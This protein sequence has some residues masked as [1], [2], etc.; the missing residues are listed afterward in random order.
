M[1]KPASTARLR[2]ARL[3]SHG[4]RTGLPSI[5]AAA[6]R[7]AA[8]QAQDFVAAKWVL[9]A[10]VPGSV[11][12][13]VDSAIESR[14]IVRSW[15][16]RGTLHL[17]PT[18][19]LRPILAITG[20]REVQRDATRRRQLELDD[21]VYAK[22]RDIAERELAGGSLSRD[23][24]FAA[25]EA[26]GIATAAQRGYHLTWWLAVDAVICCGPVEGRGQRFVLLDE[27]APATSAAPDRE[28][29]LGRLFT[30]YA[31]GHGPATVRDFAWWT[32]LTLGDAR[33]AVAAAG[34]T[35][36]AFDDERYV[37]ADAG[38]TADPDAAA[39]R[40]GGRLALAPFDEYFLGY[41]D[42]SPVCD[43]GHAPRVVPSSNGV[44]QPILVAAG[45]VEGVWKVTRARGAASVAVQGF[46]RE[47]DPSRYRSALAAW[48]RFQGE[49]LDAVVAA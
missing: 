11:A 44:F 18:E 22:A 25:W 2:A 43:P 23:E 46:E 6:R 33:T 36:V 10:R 1:P 20:P 5:A 31:A 14:E 8:V 21:E 39:P 12:A 34:D 16:L 49:T 32:G 40:P 37:A 35:V 19:T 17:L 47:V 27:W 7:L 41:G 28:E 29:T 13:D 30:S 4:L 48:A 38:W 26:A 3:E 24:L 15:P 9:G 45:V 42:R